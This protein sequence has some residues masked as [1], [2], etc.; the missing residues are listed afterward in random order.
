[1]GIIYAVED[2]PKLEALAR[3][4]TRTRPGDIAGWINLA[5]AVRRTASVAEAR[6]VLQAAQA[7]VPDSSALLH[8]N[9]ACYECVLGE[10]DAAKAR[11]DH[12]LQLDPS[13]AGV[14]K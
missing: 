3:G 13:L 8:Y 5:F 6:K 4:F 14:A 9:L 1:M 11:L 7:Q 10:T 2:W 12:A